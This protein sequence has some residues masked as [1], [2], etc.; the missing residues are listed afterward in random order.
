VHRYFGLLG[1]VTAPIFGLKRA[2]REFSLEQLPFVV[3]NIQKRDFCAFFGHAGGY[4][5]AKPKRRSSNNCD[6]F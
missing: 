4:G 2:P 5:P 6:F 3:Q 1:N